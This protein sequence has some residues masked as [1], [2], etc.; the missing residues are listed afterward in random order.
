M[1]KLEEIIARIEAFDALSPAEMGEETC[2]AA[3]AFWDNVED[4]LRWAMNELGKFHE[5][6]NFRDGASHNHVTE[7]DEDGNPAYGSH[8]VYHKG[9]DS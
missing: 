9:G 3:E 6:D 2:P 5:C 8:T 7:V 4:D 1:G